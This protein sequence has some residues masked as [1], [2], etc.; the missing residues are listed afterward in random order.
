ML[1]TIAENVPAHFLLRHISATPNHSNAAYRS[2][3]QYRS[4]R[5]ILILLFQGESQWIVSIEP[6][7]SYFAPDAVCLSRK[8]HFADHVVSLWSCPVQGA[9]PV[10][11]TSL[12]WS[13]CH[14]T[15]GTDIS[16]RSN[17]VQFSS[18]LAAQMT[19]EGRNYEPMLPSINP[20]GARE[21]T[22]LADLSVA[23]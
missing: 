21:L 12:K 23:W 11:V 18:D 14:M 20:Y 8:I 19:G 10:G 6:N 2:C 5:G 22:V 3:C 15:P 9:P 4:Y 17:Q 1:R 13:P 7:S 16:S